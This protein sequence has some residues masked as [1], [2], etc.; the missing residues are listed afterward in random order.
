MC[1]FVK[2]AIQESASINP[3][4]KAK[5]ISQGKGLSFIPGAVDSASTHIGRV[6]QQV[7][8]GRLMASG[9]SN[10]DI[11]DFETI[12]DDIDKKDDEVSA[13]TPRERESLKKLCR[14]YLVS[15]GIEGGIRYIF[16]MNA[17]MC[18][19]LST[20]DFVEA[21]ITFNE[22][23]EYPYLFNMVA[24]DEVTMEWSIVSRIR[25]DKQDAN[26]HAL[27]FKKTFD[28]CKQSYPDFKLGETLV[29]VVVDWSDA[30]IRGLR[31]AVGKDLATNLL[32][33][34]KVHWARSWQR[35]RDR[36]AKS[37]DKPREKTVFSKI[38][39][40]ITEVK[41]GEKV[42]KCF[43]A[44]CGEIKIVSVLDVIPELDKVDAEF[45][46]KHCDWVA[47]KHW[48]A[49]WMR[50]AHLQMLHKDFSSMTSDVWDECPTNTNAVERR[51]QD[52]KEGSPLPIRQCVPSMYKLV[53]AFCAKF[54]AAKN[55]NNLSYNSRT[56]ESRKAAAETRQSQR[57]MAA[58]AQIEKGHESQ[59]GPPDKKQHFQD[60]RKRYYT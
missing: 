57:K 51:N 11:G 19:L 25:M 52:C 10:W 58:T 59:F 12:A 13:K 32:R 6:A 28:A 30:E 8:K 29:G 37:S 20:S 41:G 43:K 4:L 26:A 45:V 39:S 55:G 1:S 21:D 7:K 3:Q 36:V 47:A 42:L 16:T 9:G 54:L 49:W 38:A 48:A 15:A 24:F 44:L 14:P 31:T 33:G 46:D 22:S 18:Q 56:V 5:Q 23:L 53:K 27:A 34:C 40:K 2:K 35:V 60:T 50:P 17:L